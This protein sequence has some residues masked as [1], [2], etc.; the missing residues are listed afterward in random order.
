MGRQHDSSKNRS[1]SSRQHS[2]GSTRTIVQ[3][4]HSRPTSRLPLAAVRLLSSR[5]TASAHSRQ[6]SCCC[7]SFCLHPWQ[8]CRCVLRAAQERQCNTASG[9]RLPHACFLAHYIELL[10]LAPLAS[11]ECKE[12]HEQRTQRVSMH[13]CIRHPLFPCCGCYCRALAGE[14]CQ[15]SCGHWRCCATGH[16]TPGW[17]LCLHAA[18]SSWASRSVLALTPGA[19]PSACGRLRGWGAALA[20]AGSSAAAQ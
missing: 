20:S 10:G 9:F 13:N 16:R 5:A 1:H 3:H 15:P 14:S 18:A 2:S 6:C 12:E 7:S 19:L 11:A 4:M 17:R 8:R